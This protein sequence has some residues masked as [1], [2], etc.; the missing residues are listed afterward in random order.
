MYKFLIVYGQRYEEEDERRSNK[1][2]KG[3]SKASV[4]LKEKVRK[5][6]KVTA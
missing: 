5:H 4:N 1:N 6:L 2:Y 3:K